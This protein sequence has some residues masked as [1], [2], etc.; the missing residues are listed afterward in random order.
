VAGSAPISDSLR[1]E[2]E[3]AIAQI[4]TAG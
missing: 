1:T 3:A 2:V 4:T